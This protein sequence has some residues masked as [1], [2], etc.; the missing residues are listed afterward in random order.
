MRAHDCN[1]SPFAYY[2][3]HD[4]RGRPGRCYYLLKRYEVPTDVLA[5]DVRKGR[6]RRDM[7]PLYNV[8][9]TLHGCCDATGGPRRRCLSCMSAAD[10]SMCAAL[11]FVR[12]RKKCRESNKGGPTRELYN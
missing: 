3:F 11:G 2:A 10:L 7:L 5:Q 9:R 12:C 1:V 4:L 6:Q 8:G